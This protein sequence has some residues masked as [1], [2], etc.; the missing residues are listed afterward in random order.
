MSEVIL[1]KRA[2]IAI[3]YQGHWLLLDAV[4]GLS[5]DSSV[6]LSGP[7]RKTLFGYSP[8]MLSARAY[9]PISLNLS[10]YITKG[11][12][13]VVFFNMMGFS[14][15][16]KNKITLSYP[17]MLGQPQ[18]TQ[19]IYVQDDVQGSFVLSNCVVEGIDIP[20]SMMDQGK[21]DVTISQS[22]LQKTNITLPN[23]LIKQGQH[24]IPDYIHQSLAG[25]DFKQVGQALTIQRQYFTLESRN[26]FNTNEIVESN[27]KLVSDSMLGVSIQ[28]YARDST[29]QL[30][31][32]SAGGLIIKQQGLSVQLIDGNITK[33]LSITD[34]PQIYW[35][36]KNTNTIIITG[37]QE[38][39]I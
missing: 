4:Q 26:C 15:N 10:T 39:Q 19:N 38:E 36:Y 13:E 27:N 12:H 2:K 20:F 23:S 21:L 1:L 32:F 28:E 7:S 30:P 22:N 8:D 37:P 24:C 14:N 18:N 35:D 9:N 17:E 29:L 3:E 16:G 31:D 11:F 33:R 5:G 34:V 6:Q 25:Y